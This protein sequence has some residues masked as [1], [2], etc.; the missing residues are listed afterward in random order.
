M[1]EIDIGEVL[2]RAWDIED[3]VRILMDEYDIDEDDAWE[4]VEEYLEFESRV[5][6]LRRS[7]K[8]KQSRIVEYLG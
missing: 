5:M 8:S 1:E 4:L 3:A 7:G 6:K 2:E